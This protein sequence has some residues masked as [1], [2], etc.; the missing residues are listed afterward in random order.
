MKINP[1]RSQKFK[2]PV[3]SMGAEFASIPSL[4]IADTKQPLC[5]QSSTLG[6]G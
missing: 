3:P 6:I 2:F 5:M 1:L 4:K